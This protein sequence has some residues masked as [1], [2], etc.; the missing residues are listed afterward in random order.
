MSQQQQPGAIL[1]RPYEQ[2][3]ALRFGVGLGIGGFTVP[4]DLLAEAGPDR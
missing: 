3:L 4:F 1:V 2:L